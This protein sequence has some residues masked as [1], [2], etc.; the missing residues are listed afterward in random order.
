E[1]DFSFGKVFRDALDVGATHVDA[2][3]LDAGGIRV[4]A[5]DMISET[6]N[7]RRIIAFGDVDDLPRVQVDEQRDVVLAALGRSLID[8]DASQVRAVHARHRLL[9]IVLDEAPQTR[10]VLADEAGGSCDRHALDEGHDERLEQKREAGSGPC[11]RHID[12]AHATVTTIDAGDTR[13][14]EGLVLKEI[15]VAPGLLDGVVHRAVGLAT[16]GAREAAAH[17][18]VDLDIEPLLVG[19]RTWSP[20]PSTAAPGR[21]RA[22]IDRYRACLSSSPRSPPKHARAQVA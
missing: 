3:L 21:V 15:E 6:S 12:Q 5:V 13:M 17:L 20:P 7:S 1:G 10:V 2:H 4:V 22:G 16:I 8:G 18:E 19:R 9:D 14:Q 11:P